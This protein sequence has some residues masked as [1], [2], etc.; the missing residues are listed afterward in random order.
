MTP[1]MQQQTQAAPQPAASNKPEIIGLENVDLK[2]APKIDL[3]QLEPGQGGYTFT[4][5]GAIKFNG[6]W[7]PY[8]L[9]GVKDQ[10]GNIF[11]FFSNKQITTMIDEKKEPFT[12][13]GTSFFIESRLKPG[14]T[15]KTKNG[16]EREAKGYSYEIRAL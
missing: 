4:W 14:M 16:E 6:Q 8:Y 9:I 10:N 15:Y 1:L 12:A 5:L 11:K 3:K 13:P 2:D 7:G